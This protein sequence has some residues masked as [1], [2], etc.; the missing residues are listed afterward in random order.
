MPPALCSLR[1][2]T[3]L[4]VINRHFLASK[5]KECEVSPQASDEVVTPRNTLFCLLYGNSA[6]CIRL[7]LPPAL[8]KVLVAENPAELEDEGRVHSP[9]L[10]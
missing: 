5:A 2:Q 7:F 3:K 10:Q 4:L 1:T 9:P 8:E 6:L